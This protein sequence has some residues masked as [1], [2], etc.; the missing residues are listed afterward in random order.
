MVTVKPEAEEY[1]TIGLWLDDERPMPDHQHFTHHATTAEE[2]IELLQK[3]NF[4]FI[5][6]DHDLGIGRK[7]G[8]DVACFIEQEAVAGRMPFAN[9]TLHTANPVGRDRMAHAIRHAYKHWRNI[10]HGHEG[11][12]GS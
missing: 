3:M 2:A 11:E 7:T 9:V 12:D 1:P 4:S 8:Y 10:D 6:L 5:S